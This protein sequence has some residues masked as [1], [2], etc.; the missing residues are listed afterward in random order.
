MTVKEASQAWG[1]DRRTILKWILGKDAT[2]RGRRLV[3]G[4]D[5]QVVGGRGPGGHQYDILIT[6]YPMPTGQSLAPIPKHQRGIKRIDSTGLPSGDMTEAERLEAEA[7]AKRPVAKEPR[8]PVAPKVPRLPKPPKAPRAPKAEELETAAERAEREWL[9][10]EAPKPQR[11]KRVRAAPVVEVAPEPV[12]EE[13]VVEEPVVEERPIDYSELP[14]RQQLAVWVRSNSNNP[15]DQEDPLA[16]VGRF[17]SFLALAKS[18]ALSLQ[19]LAAQGQGVVEKRLREALAETPLTPEARKYAG[20]VSLEF[21]AKY[22]GLKDLST[23]YPQGYWP[24]TPSQLSAI[25][26]F[27]RA[28][29]EPMLPPYEW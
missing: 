29:E 12:I 22:S 26:S 28:T 24:K 8:E 16:A 14:I 7:M 13:T 1:V 15:D 20:G 17:T 6:N 11:Q 4:R 9:G 21:M 19:S 27:G 25:Y 18:G 5:Y 10:G 3:E 23:T 2:G